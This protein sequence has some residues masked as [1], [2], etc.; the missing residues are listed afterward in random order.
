MQNIFE[1]AHTLVNHVRANFPEDI[2]LIAYYGSYAQGTAAKRSD[3]D[4]FFIPATSDGYRASLQFVLEDISF[5]FWPISWERAER[6]AAFEE[7]QTTI[8]ANCEILYVRSD[9]DC[10]RFLKL[11]E[12]TLQM[13]R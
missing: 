9:E 11:R 7:P 4:F 6:M 8:I 13:S 1:V 2:A 5:D 10:A 3:L 12:T